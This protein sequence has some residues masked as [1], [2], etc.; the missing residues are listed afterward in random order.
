ML[1]EMML[2]GLQ[3]GDFITINFT[4]KVKETGEVFDTTVKDVAKKERLYKEGDVYEPKLVVIGGGWVLKALD[5]SL[6]TMETSKTSPVEIPPDKAF[7]PRD[8]EKVKRVPLKQLLAKEMVPTI[9]MSL[10]YGGKNATGQQFTINVTINDV[11][12]L[13]GFDLKF[14]WNTTYLAYVSRSVLVPNDTYPHGVLRS[15]VLLVEDQANATDGTYWTAYAA[16]WRAPSFNGSG[17]LLQYF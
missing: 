17:S 2:M 4:A 1:Q 9:G 15:P 13:Y 14:R 5:E 16:M 12:N 10:E 8:P 7:G 6:I 3:K 11:T